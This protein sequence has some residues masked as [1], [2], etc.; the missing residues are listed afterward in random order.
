MSI[1]TT[2]ILKNA[3]D[4]AATDHGIYEVEVLGG[5]HDVE[6][7]TWYADHMTQTLADA[8][9][10][11]NAPVG[12]DHKQPA[13]APEAALASTVE[14]KLEVLV[15]P[16]SD[17]D[18]AKDFYEKA[19]FRL[20]ADFNISEELRIIQV[21]P[22]GSEMSIIFGTGVTESTPGSVQN[23]HLIV[24]DIIAA[25]AELH[26]RG[27][28]ISEV[29]HDADGLFHRPGGRNRV[30]GPSPDRADYGSFASFSDPDGN[31][32]FLQEVVTRAPGR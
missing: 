25:Q 27:I 15:L 21:T 12:S 6:W 28:D 11:L 2:E 8:G 32:W 16:V 7:P 5:V 23:L 22:P 31:G 10:S 1:P 13:A 3:L 29:W 20:D 26:S 24:T 9:Y 30:S 14:L 18:R 4:Q 19:G 17:V